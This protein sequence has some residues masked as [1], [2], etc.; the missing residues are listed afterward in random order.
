MSDSLIVRPPEQTTSFPQ[1][2]WDWAEKKAKDIRKQHGRRKINLAEGLYSCPLPYGFRA[3]IESGNWAPLPHET[4]TVNCQTA[5]FNLYVVAKKLGL[6]PQMY[7]L[8]GIRNPGG[9]HGSLHFTVDVDVGATHRVVVDPL[10][11]IFGYYKVDENRIK[12]VRDND[13]TRDLVKEFSSMFPVSEEE[14]AEKL[15]FQRT[16]QGSLTM[17]LEGQKIERHHCDRWRS[18]VYWVGNWFV[19]YNP[20]HRLL[21][22][23]INFDRPLIQH[24]TLTLIT[25]LDENSAVKARTVSFDCARDTNWFNPQDPTFLAEFDWRD[26]CPLI[27]LL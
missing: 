8:V 27:P 14:Y 10:Q 6:N 24:R 26:M 17:L 2:T 12:I 21:W 5:A 20:E 18:N 15:K 1:E 7:A 9:P 23:R 13:T 19:R 3:N 16:P 25:E 11:E 22:T 4:K